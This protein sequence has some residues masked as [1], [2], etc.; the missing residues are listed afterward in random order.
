[1]DLTLDVL[2][3]FGAQLPTQ[4]LA[5][6]YN[7]FRMGSPT[8]YVEEDLG[9]ILADSILPEETFLEDVKFPWPSF[10]LVL[11]KGLLSH[12]N[13]EYYVQCIDIAFARPGDIISCPKDI[14]RDL[15]MG[16]FDPKYN[17]PE[18]ITM[19]TEMAG[20]SGLIQVNGFLD[21][22]SNQYFTF[23]ASFDVA[24]KLGIFKHASEH[25]D[26]MNMTPDMAQ[27]YDRIM[28][29]SMNAVLLYSAVPVQYEPERVQR[30]LR[31]E[32]KRLIPALVHPH[33]LGDQLLSARKHGT[34]RN[35]TE[36]LT[37]KSPHWRRAH[38]RRQPFGKGLRERRL[39]WI[40]PMHIGK[41]SPETER[42]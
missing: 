7:A 30:K 39:I 38:W 17:F 27:L 23:S 42:R 26:T 14:H 24:T 3:S 13:L 33:W 22:R 11:P 18:V 37:H 9:Q 20:Q 21:S 31:K 6:L 35:N 2:Y 16:N 36:P 19:K 28:L 34:A 10:R 41:L 15:D 1:M 4:S 25:Y 32:G 8:I 40:L 12:S 29:F 5:Y